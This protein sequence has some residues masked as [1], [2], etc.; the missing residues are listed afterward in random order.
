MNEVTCKK[1]GWVHFEINRSD[2]GSEAFG[3]PLGSYL[4]C[5]KC[6]GSYVN[7]RDSTR[8]EAPLGSTLQ[9][10]LARDQ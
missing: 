10:V 8:D 3:G 1:C 6:G 7:F 4:K 5:F 2:I 9:P